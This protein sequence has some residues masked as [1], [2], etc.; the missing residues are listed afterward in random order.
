[1]M[2]PISFITLLAFLVPV[3]GHSQNP[4]ST[5]FERLEWP[6]SERVSEGLAWSVF[7]QQYFLASNWNASGLSV[8]RVLGTG[9]SA[10][11]FCRDGI[12][13]YAWYHLYLSHYHRFKG[14][15]AMIQLRF[16][17]I[18]LIEHPAVFRLGGTIQ[19]D[20]S[21]A[22][23]LCLQSTV[24]DFPGWLLPVPRLT[25]GNPHMQFLLFHE[26][27]RLIGLTTGFRISRNQFGPVVSGIRVNWGD[28]I[29]LTGLLGVLPFG[30][31]LGI[32]WRP[33]FLWFR[34]WFREVNGLGITP[35]IELGG[36]TVQ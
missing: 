13:G 19:I 31:S 9:I 16:S 17:I 34:G 1:M 24:H 6:A 27:G 5:A 28:Q 4:V 8:S 11:M 2:R 10:A 7:S 14:F 18:D 32:T 26:P 22:E 25:S 21:I 33:E 20:W 3:A 35:M 15:G 29:G 23:R 30:I 36:G 12:A